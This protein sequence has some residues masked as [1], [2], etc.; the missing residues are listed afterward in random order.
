LT[1]KMTRNSRQQLKP[2]RS[3]QGQHVEK[4][5]QKLLTKILVQIPATRK[6]KM[7]RMKKKQNPNLRQPK[8]QLDLN[9]ALKLQNRLMMRYLLPAAQQ[10]ELD[11]VPVPREEGDGTHKRYYH[12]LKRQ[13]ETATQ[14]I[15]SPNQAAISNNMRGFVMQK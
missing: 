10:A 3:R 15:L 7:K 11:E 8:G 14:L 13:Q 1:K 4:R 12:L 5:Q 6:I 9:V 2:R